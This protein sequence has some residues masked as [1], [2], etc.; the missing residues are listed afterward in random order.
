[1][2][3]TIVRFRPTIFLLASMPWDDVGTS[4]EVFTPW[5][6]MMDAAIAAFASRAW[7]DV[8]VFRRLPVGRTT[9]VQPGESATSHP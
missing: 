5:V 8:G 4:V 1:M 3:V 7:A 6:S 2:A 9:V